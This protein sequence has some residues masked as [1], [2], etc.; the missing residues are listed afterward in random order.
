[1]HSLDTTHLRSGATVN[2]DDD[3]PWWDPESLPAPPPGYPPSPPPVSWKMTQSEVDYC[4]PNLADTKFGK[5]ALFPPCKASDELGYYTAGD[6][7]PGYDFVVYERRD[8]PESKQFAEVWSLAYKQLLRQS[9]QEHSRLFGGVVQARTGTNHEGDIFHAFASDSHFQLSGLAL[10]NTVEDPTTP[11]L[12]IQYL[13]EQAPT[14]VGLTGNNNSRIW[15]N[16]S[17][18]DHSNP[19]QVPITQ[20]ESGA[21][22]PRCLGVGPLAFYTPPSPPDTSQTAATPHGGVIGGFGNPNGAFACLKSCVLHG[23]GFKGRMDDPGQKIT[24][25]GKAWLEFQQL[26]GF[27]MEWKTHTFQWGH[28]T[29]TTYHPKWKFESNRPDIGSFMHWGEFKFEAKVMATKEIRC[30]NSNIAL[31]KGAAEAPWPEQMLFN[32]GGGGE[33]TYWWWNNKTDEAMHGGSPMKLFYQVVKDIAHRADA[34]TLKLNTGP[35]CNATN[36]TNDDYQNCWGEYK[37]KVEDCK[38]PQAIQFKLSD[39]TGDPTT[40]TEAIT[41]CSAGGPQLLR[42]HPNKA[43]AH[44]AYLRLC[45]ACVTAC[46]VRKSCQLR[47][48]RITHMFYG[49]P[50]ALTPKSDLRK[51]TGLVK[52]IGAAPLCANF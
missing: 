15:I 52:S 44:L 27:D 3:H 1:M 21:C 13:T 30:L 37:R 43:A 32:S 40:S 5:W 29:Y 9:A 38:G 45:R 48:L 2:A 36:P 10:G 25:Y 20:D 41:H 12:T 46:E 14:N 4:N 11:P 17:T 28:T 33:P 26:A 50:Y 34:N 6:W 19:D 18:W 22:V 8:R 7:A 42:A 47:G 49:D 23:E 51:F 35:L 39:G 24:G 31:R 16:P